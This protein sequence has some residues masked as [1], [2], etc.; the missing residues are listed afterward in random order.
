MNG[1]G[2]QFKD[3]KT[4]RVYGN[5]FDWLQKESARTGI[6]IC[7]LVALAVDTLRLQDEKRRGVK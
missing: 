4:V 2:M 6:P 3:S 5:T 1:K 7:R